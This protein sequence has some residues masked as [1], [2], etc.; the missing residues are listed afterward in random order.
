MVETQLKFIPHSH[1][2][3][4]KCYV[5]AS[6]GWLKDPG[7][8]NAGTIP[9]ASATPVSTWQ[10]EEKSPEV[11]HWFFK[12]HD[13]PLMAHIITLIFLWLDFSWCLVS[14]CPHPTEGGLANL[15]EVCAPEGETEFCKQL[16]MFAR[17]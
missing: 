4:S 13:M 9:W 16:A 15:I 10:K 1:Y 6:L 14:W 11:L 5:T 12:G 2:G 7:S 17:I 8:F 3:P